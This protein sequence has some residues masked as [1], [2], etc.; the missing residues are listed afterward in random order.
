MT[1][2]S[3]LLDFDLEYLI[4]QMAKF[5]AGTPSGH[6][7]MQLDYGLNWYPE[8]KSLLQELDSS[9]AKLLRLREV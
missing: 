6:W 5:Q 2:S 8:P 9:V 7:M 3:S 1:G 4:C